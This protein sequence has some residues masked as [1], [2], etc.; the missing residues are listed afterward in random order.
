M[1]AITDPRILAIMSKLDKTV[2]VNQDRSTGKDKDGTG[3]EKPPRPPLN[4][5]EFL[6]LEHLVSFFRPLH[7]HHTTCISTLALTY[8]KVQTQLKC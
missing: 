3:T 8:D 5:E 4:V 1:D 7:L 2:S 6:K